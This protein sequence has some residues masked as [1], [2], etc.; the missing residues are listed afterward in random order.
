M[1]FCYNAYAVSYFTVVRR[2]VNICIY[3]SSMLY[4]FSGVYRVCR[5]CM[6]LKMLCVPIIMQVGIA[7]LAL[8]F[9]W[10]SLTATH[11]WT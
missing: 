3:A 4:F 8:Q 6:A 10:N 9:W 1:Q 11:P 7:A 2:Q 5:V